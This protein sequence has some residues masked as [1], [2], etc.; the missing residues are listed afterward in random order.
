[1]EDVLPGGKRNEPDEASRHRLRHSARPQRQTPPRLVPVTRRRLLLLLGL[2]S[3][4]GAQFSPLDDWGE[5]RSFAAHMAQHLLLGDLG[6]LALVAATARWIPRP[7]GLA[8]L[9]LWVT[10][11]ALWHVPAVYEAALHHGAVHV[12]QHI[13]LLVAGLVLWSAILRSPLRIGTH[14][15]LV[16]GMMLTGLV[17]SSLFLWWPRV[18]YS[19]YAHAH[20]PLFGMAPLTDQRGG[21]G[22]MLLEGMLVA[23]G[24]AAWLI[25]SLLRSA[26]ADASPSP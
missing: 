6:P 14:L 11:L 25:F 8:A 4:A 23:V 1:M 20:H 22:L 24:A 9:P 7:L 26:E 16:V 13:T 21:G 12:L 3:I 2:A 15:L 17:L 10:S 5:H 18:L 19:T